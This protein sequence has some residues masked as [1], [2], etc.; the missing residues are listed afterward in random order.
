MYTGTQNEKVVAHESATRTVGYPGYNEELGFACNDEGQTNVVK[1]V[2]LRVG[3]QEEIDSELANIC[4]I[5]GKSY[6]S[7]DESTVVG[8]SGTSCHLTR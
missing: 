4:K 7:F 8:D 6:P 2:G 5:D 1:R 3:F